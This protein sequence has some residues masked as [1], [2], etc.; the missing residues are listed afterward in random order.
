MEVKGANIPPPAAAQHLRGI[1]NAFLGQL[2]SSGVAVVV[3]RRS[4][5]HLSC[6]LA[7][8]PPP[9]PTQRSCGSAHRP[10]QQ[11]GEELGVLSVFSL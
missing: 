1:Q 2:S 6:G 11:L 7:L 3:K 5:P 9:R 10:L 4:P 8:P